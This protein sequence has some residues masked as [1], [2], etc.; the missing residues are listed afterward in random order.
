MS[1]QTTPHAM[2]GGEKKKKKKDIFR[3]FDSADFSKD[4]N[5]KI[6]SQNLILKKERGILRKNNL[7][8]GFKDLLHY[9]ER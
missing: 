1:R 9:Q 6:Y 3:H 4:M 7:I 5:L 8:L 2:E